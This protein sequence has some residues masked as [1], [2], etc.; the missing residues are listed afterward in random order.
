MPSYKGNVGNL[1]QH[2]VFCEIIEA[3]RGHAEQLAL[4]DAYSMGALCHPENGKAGGL[5]RPRTGPITGP[6]KSIRMHMAQNPETPS[7]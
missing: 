7:S 6:T 4:V 5:L 2:W 3:C 1:L